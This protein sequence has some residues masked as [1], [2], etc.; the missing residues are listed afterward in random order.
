MLKHWLLFLF[1][2]HLAVFSYQLGEIHGDYFFLLFM[3]DLIFVPI[4]LLLYGIDYI[5]RKSFWLKRAVWL[6]VVL[7]AILATTAWY[8]YFYR[9]LIFT[10]LE[11]YIQQGDGASGSFYYVILNANNSSSPEHLTIGT[12]DSWLR[13]EANETTPNTYDLIISRDKN[14]PAAIVVNYNPQPVVGVN[15]LLPVKGNNNIWKDWVPK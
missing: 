3:G 4:G 14:G 6:S 2:L 11:M 9:V 5:R 15:A 13:F 1:L 12:S 7:P 8:V 10:D